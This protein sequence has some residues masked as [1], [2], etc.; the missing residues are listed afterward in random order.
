M[1]QKVRQ[2]IEQRREGRVEP[3]VEALDLR[4]RTDA[5]T[6]ETQANKRAREDS[7]L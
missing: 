5:Q 7:N 4:R 2:K 6:G 1:R 3:R